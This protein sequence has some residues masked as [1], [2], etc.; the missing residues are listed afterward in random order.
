MQRRPTPPPNESGEPRN[1]VPPGG[2]DMLMWGANGPWQ[3]SD[4]RDASGAAAQSIR[5]M[6][7]SC[8]IN[9]VKPTGAFEPVAAVEDA[10]RFSARQIPSCQSV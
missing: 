8:E 9:N 3:W 7:V 10:P 2:L 4:S 1:L 5:A 6:V